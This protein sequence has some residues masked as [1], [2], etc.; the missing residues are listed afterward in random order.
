MANKLFSLFED[1]LRSPQDLVASTP[2]NLD[3]IGQD[4]EDPTAILRMIQQFE[5]V[6]P[7]ADYSDFSNF[8]FFNSALDYFN[9]TGEKILNE[10]PFDA[11]SADLQLWVNSLDEYQRYVVDVWPS[12]VG[13]LR[14]NPA[15]G[16]AYVQAD[17]VYRADED[18]HSQTALVT[19]GTGSFSLDFWAIPPPALTGTVDAMMLFTKFSSSAGIVTF[20]SG[21]TLNFGVVSG[22]GFDLTSVPFVPGQPTYFCFSYD[23]TGPLP[24][25]NA[26]TG[27]VS[28][29]PVL[30]AG[31]TGTLTNNIDLGSSKIYVGSG[32]LPGRTVIPLTGALDDLK[33]WSIPRT[34]SEITSSFNTRILAQDGLSV[35]WRFNET[36]SLPAGQREIVSDASGHRLSGRIQNYFAGVRGS[37]SIIPFDEPDLVL[38]LDEPAVATYISTQQLSGTI[39]DRFNDNI[40]TRMMPEQFFLLEEFKNTTVLQDFL[41]VIARYFD[42]LKVMIDQFANVLKNDYG[43]FDNTPDALLEDVGRFFGWEF[44]GNFLNSDAVQY[45]LGKQVLPNLDYNRAI[46][47]KLFEIKNEFWKRTLINLM[48]LYKTKGTRESVESLLRIYGAN[49]NFIRLK[50]YGYKPNVGIQTFRIAAEKSVFALT[51]GSGSL[52]TRVVSSPFTGSAQTVESRVMFPTATTTGM[53]ASLQ[54]GSIWTINSASVPETQLMQLFYRKQDLNLLT[55]NLYYTGSEGLLSLS[56][57]I[58]DGRWYN[59]AV[60]RNQLS[61][62]VFLDVR[63]IDEDTVFLHVSSTLPATISTASYVIDMC[64]GATGSSGAQMWAQE[65]RVWEQA[66][67]DVELNDHALNFQSY[68]TDGPNEV[69]TLDLQWRLSENVTASL[70]PP[71][72]PE[73]GVFSVYDW[74]GQLNSGTAHG[75]L[76]GVSAYRKFLNSYNYI[77]P[78]EYG[79]NEVK[80]RALDTTYVKPE[81]A[82]LD[83]PL[84]ALEFNLVDALNEDISQI[85][86]SLDGFNIS[87]GSPVDAYRDTYQDLE[88]LRRNYFKRLRGSINFRVFADMLEFFDR[89]FVD[90]VK[91]LIPVRATFLGDEFVVESHMLER[92]KLQWNYRRR[93]EDLEPEG[94][95]R[96]YIRS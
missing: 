10:Y 18:T 56:A 57:P 7:K 48:H 44:T 83:S 91:R 34:L 27:S 41:Y 82:F 51:F 59:V 96:I 3:A 70:G 40:I 32:T 93:T 17:D 80:V 46:D 87:M 55:G 77:A 65:V 4:V 1:K 30:A 29:F 43:R 37:G 16:W 76:Q 92:P 38:S 13:H 69:T 73:G 95:I 62:A 20:Y 49:K 68:G 28:Q 67:S 2:K 58:F 90:M 36:G 11:G 71:N 47:T 60:V 81:D 74:S 8:V 86:S 89:S 61:G 5:V 24:I 85:I 66:L 72:T 88:V 53:T 23:R 25:L 78:P 12:S 14:F 45:I 50:E 79:W 6:R 26:F 22:S 94:R 52:T 75:F 21:S 9:I 63:G 35:F 64:L 19:L 31:I 42:S 15:S 84:L 54:T 33:I 39:Y